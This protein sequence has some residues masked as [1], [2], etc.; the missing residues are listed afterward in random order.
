[1]QVTFEQGRVDDLQEFFAASDSRRSLHERRCC[2]RVG[3]VQLFHKVAA[4]LCGK[5]KKVLYFTS[6]FETTLGFLFSS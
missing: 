5:L 2:G 6:L 4:F 1:M 3:V